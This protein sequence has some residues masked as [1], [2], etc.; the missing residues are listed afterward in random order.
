MSADSLSPPK[1][2]REFSKSSKPILSML[3]DAGKGKVTENFGKKEWQI[4]ASNYYAAVGQ[5]DKCIGHLFD[6][7]HNKGILE[8]TII[9]L[10]SDHGEQLGSYGFDQK[11]TLYDASIRIPFIVCGKDIPIGEK[12]ECLAEQVDII[13]TLLDMANTTPPDTLSGMSLKKQI[14]TWRGV[15]K[16]AVYGWL[17][18]LGLVQAS[19]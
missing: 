18:W 1:N 8:N 11:E 17:N 3:K 2:F 14:T 7:L 15:E 6:T 16:E 10:T 5:V 12:R 4:Y 19:T 9:I 13:P